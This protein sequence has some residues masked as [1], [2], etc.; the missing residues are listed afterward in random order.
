LKGNF[1][2]SDS[3]PSWAV[4]HHGGIES[5]L[6]GGRSLERGAIHEQSL[7]WQGE[8]HSP[9]RRATVAHVAAECPWSIRLAA[10]FEMAPAAG[11]PGARPPRRVG[12]S[13]IWH[14]RGRLSDPFVSY[15]TGTLQ[16]ETALCIMMLTDHW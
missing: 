15:F 8:G 4:Y 5:P 12:F 11:G 1:G 6:R 2:L 16:P 9:A 14:G 7:Q 13:L 10:T 3:P